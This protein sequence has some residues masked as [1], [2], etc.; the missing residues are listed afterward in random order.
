MCVIRT[1]S[2]KELVTDFPFLSAEHLFLLFYL[3]KLNQRVLRHRRRV[4][5]R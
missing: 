1:L 4:Q 2:L 5:N 3:E